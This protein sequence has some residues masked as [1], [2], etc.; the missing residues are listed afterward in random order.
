MATERALRSEADR[1]A[2]QSRLESESS[3]AARLADAVRQFEGDKVH[4]MQTEAPAP[5]LTR[6]PWCGA[7]GFLPRRHPPAQAPTRCRP[8]QGEVAR[9]L[10]S[11]P[12]A[13][14]GTVVVS[15]VLR[16]QGLDTSRLEADNE[17]L[18]A[19]LAALQRLADARV[20][21]GPGASLD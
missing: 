4:C 2:L 13:L 3:R 21:S 14:T 16:V 7:S 20:A 19:E 15:L 6:G 12:H 18:R 9:P 8:E 10:D 5:G 17:R 11:A 1:D